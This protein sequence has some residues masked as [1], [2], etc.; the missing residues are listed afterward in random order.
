M[1]GIKIT[2]LT[3]ATSAELTDVIPVVTGGETD[4]ITLQNFRYSLSGVNNSIASNDASWIAAG[5]NCDIN[6]LYDFIG[7]GENNAI[8][9]DYNVISGGS[10]NATQGNAQHNWLAGKN[11]IVGGTSYNV[12]AGEGN[13]AYS[14]WATVMGRSNI[15][16]SGSNYSVVSGYQNETYG[17]ESLIVGR[18]N[19]IESAANN[20]VVTGRGAIARLAGQRSHALSYFSSRGDS[21]YI[22]LITRCLTTAAAS[23]DDLNIGTSGLITIAED[24]AMFLTVEVAG[25]TVDGADSAHYI[26]KVA[27]KNILGT[28]SLIGSVST[29]GT[30][31]E[32]QAG[33]DI[34]ITADAPTNSLKITVTGDPVKTMRWVG[35]ISGVQIAMA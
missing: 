22:D 21:Q 15:A 2:E 28:T 35:F 26:R 24:T 4:K 23:A 16:G 3:E 17:D 11:N 10:G 20:S 18:D 1:A 25:F 32:S 12:I 13:T 27:I 19:R 33:Y 34:S 9:G 29:I 8:Q 31:E 14:A 7:G 30:D 5:E 6:G